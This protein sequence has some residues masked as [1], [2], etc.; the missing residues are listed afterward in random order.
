MPIAI[1]AG[2]SGLTGQ[3]LLTQLI[4]SQHYQRIITLERRTSNS[5][6]NIHQVMPVDFN[7]LPALPPCDDAYC[8][9]GTTIKKAGSKESFRK[10]DYDAVLAFATRA[11]DA[12]AQKLFVVSAL[13]AS[14]TSAVF[15]NRV[16]GEMENAVSLLGYKAVHIFQP[17]LLLGNRAESRIIERLSIVAFNAITPQLVSSARKYRPIHVDVIAKAMLRVASRK[18]D[19][20][21]V[22]RYESD[23]IQ[24]M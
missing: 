7:A 13:G 16:K 6:S 21:G 24:S 5:V 17:A 18:S 9:L 22:M 4:A 15:Y 2:A 8:C 1:I 19:E 3:A 11:R 12:G 23:V 20:R 14:S 10:V